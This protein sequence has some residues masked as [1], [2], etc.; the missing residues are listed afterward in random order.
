MKIKTTQPNN[1]IEEGKNNWERTDEFNKKVNEINRELL[2]KYS[3][4]L[5]TER[6]WFKQQIIKIRLWLE[7]KKRIDELSSWNNLHVTAK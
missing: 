5:S 7:M 6:N 4:V 3:L 1:L 2:D